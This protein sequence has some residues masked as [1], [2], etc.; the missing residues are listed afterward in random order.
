MDLDTPMA[1]PSYE[2][3]LTSAIAQ[4]AA[5]EATAQNKDSKAQEETGPEQLQTKPPLSRVTNIE[6]PAQQGPGDVRFI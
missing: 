3:H 5:L 6:T 4:A 2:S 1:V